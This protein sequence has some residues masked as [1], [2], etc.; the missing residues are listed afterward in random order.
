[1]SRDLDNSALFKT[2]K[3]MADLKKAL[4]L[5]AR[6]MATQDTPQGEIVA[7]SNAVQVWEGDGVD[8][9]TRVVHVDRAAQLR[10]RTDMAYEQAK[11]YGEAIVAYARDP[12]HARWLTRKCFAANVLTVGHLVEFLK[13][14]PTSSRGSDKEFLTDRFSDLGVQLLTRI[15][16]QYVEWKE[17]R[18]RARAWLMVLGLLIVAGSLIL[19]GNAVGWNNW[20]LGEAIG[21]SAAVMLAGMASCVTACRMDTEFVDPEGMGEDDELVPQAWAAEDHPDLAPSPWQDRWGQP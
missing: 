10:V 2:D 20:T 19:V 4:R 14:T 7:D 18:E 13:M 21:V 5:H 3:A 15:R 16:Y 11:M 17:R 1:M 9:T 8:Q 6:V 12:I